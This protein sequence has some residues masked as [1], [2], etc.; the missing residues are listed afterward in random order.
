MLQRKSP[1]DTDSRHYRDLPYQPDKSL[2][3]DPMIQDHHLAQ[4]L[5]EMSYTKEVE[6]IFKRAAILAAKETA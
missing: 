2:L 6:E 3:S 5:R 1:L 4:A